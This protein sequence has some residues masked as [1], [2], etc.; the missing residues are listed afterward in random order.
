MNMTPDDFED[1]RRLLAL[2]KHEQPPPGYFARFST[3]VIVRIEAAELERETKWW[4]VLLAEFDAKPILACAYGLLACG[5]LLIG[6]GAV[7][8]EENPS[9]GLPLAENS[10]LLPDP[11]A[12]SHVS[13][14]K[15]LHQVPSLREEAG[16]AGLRQSLGTE[17]ARFYFEEAPSRMP[18]RPVSFHLNG[19]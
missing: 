5:S 19:N 7:E 17:P 2:K 16:L 15:A 3:R 14:T 6:L 4:R 11:I 1:V 18:F 10:F 8:S 12:Y 13:A 9:L